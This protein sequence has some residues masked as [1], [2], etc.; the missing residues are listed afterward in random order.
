MTQRIQ[1][2]IAKAKLAKCHV[3][4]LTGRTYEVFNPQ[5]PALHGALR[6]AR[7]RAFCDLQLQC[8]RGLAALL[9]H[10]RRG[11]PRHRAR[12]GATAQPLKGKGLLECPLK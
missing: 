1:N 7:R 8:G 9:P 6:A 11:A 12:R 3:R 5:R 10:H 4:R 2:A